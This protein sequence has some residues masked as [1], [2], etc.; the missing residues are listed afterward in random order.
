VPPFPQ[1]DVKRVNLWIVTDFHGRSP[2]KVKRVNGNDNYFIGLFHNH[3]RNLLD[4][5]RFP[6]PFAPKSKVIPA[7]FA[8]VF[9]RFARSLADGFS[10]FGGG[11]AAFLRLFFSMFGKSNGFYLIPRS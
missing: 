8:P 1:P 5:I 4:G 11:C 10:R 7:Q 2:S 6:L 9:G 3:R